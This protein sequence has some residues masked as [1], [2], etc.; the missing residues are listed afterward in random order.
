MRT[1]VPLVVVVIV[2]L[3]FGAGCGGGG[4]S[5]FTTQPQTSPVSVTIGDTPPAGVAVLSFEVT[6]TGAV[7]QPG[8]ASLL[9]APAKVEIKQLETETAF[10]NT[11]NVAQGTYNS[12]DVTFANAELTILNNSSSAIVVGSTTCNVGAVCELKPSINPST[13]SFSGAPFPLTIGSTAIGLLLDFNLN[14]SIQNDL[15]INPSISF[16]QLPAA[17]GTNELDELEDV[18]GTVANKDATNNQFTLQTADSQSFTV[19]VDSS[20]KF[21]D[22]DEVGCTA[23]PQNFT[24]VQNGQLVEVDLSLIS[25]GMFVAKEVQLEDD[26]NKEDFEGTIVSLTGNPPTAFQM[27]VLDEVPDI[28]GLSVGNAVTVTLQEASF[29]IDDE[30]LDTSAFNFSSSADLLIGQEVKVRVVGSVSPGPP[31]S[32]TTDRVTLRTSQ[33][34]TTVGVKSGNNFSVP[35]AGD[36][37][38]SLFTD[39]GINTITVQT[40][41]ATDFE[42][43][44][45]PG[46]VAGLNPGDKVSLRGLLFNQPAGTP[47]V[48]VAKKVRKR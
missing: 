47:P 2:A 14:T 6:V 3:G 8:N 16:T 44:P 46:G 7:L 23:T 15:S 21:E 38:P 30:G 27:V 31:I 1:S 19:K 10:L 43:V 37:L 26:V 41:S 34:T 36:S 4:S 48:L 40:S 45:A 42:N 22:F 28:A 9:S 29:R 11:A 33:F 32:V 25:G 17:A 39:A 35:A 13:A 12:I 20:T 18:V 5:S 24:C